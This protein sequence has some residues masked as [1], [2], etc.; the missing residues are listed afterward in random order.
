MV[1]VVFIFV[2]FMVGIVLIIGF[3]VKEFMFIVFLDDV[4]GGLV[5]GLVVFIGVVFGFMFIVVYGVCFF[6]GVFWKKCDEN[7]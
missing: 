6:W 4:M 7:G 2:V 3:V 1:M 5:W